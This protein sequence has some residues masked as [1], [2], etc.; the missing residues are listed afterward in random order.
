MAATQM[1]ALKFAL[2]VVSALAAAP[3]LRA[4][5]LDDSIAKLKAVQ[6]DGA[7]NTEA[8]NAY[9]K[10]VEAGPQQITKLLSAIE[11][12]GPLG[13]NWLRGAAEAIAIDAIEKKTLPAAD[14]ETFALDDSHDP[15]AR[16][17]AYEWVIAVDPAAADR[18]VPKLL[19]DPSVEFRRDAVQRLMEQGEKLF[20]S[21]K[22]ASGD[23]FLQAIGAARDE[24]QIKAIVEQLKK[25]ERPVDLQRHFGFLVDWQVIGPFDNT[26]R[27]GFEMAF[28]PEKERD[29]K[30]EYPGKSGQVKWQPL[31]SSDDYG[32]VD[33][34]QPY[35][36]LKET[37]A[38]AWTFFESPMDRDAELRL[39][40]KNAWKIWLNGELV[41]GR[42]EYHRGMSL[43]QYILPVKLKAGRNEILVKACQNEETQTWTTEWMFQLRVCDASGTAI[44]SA[45]RAATPRE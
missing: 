16:R 1:Q 19:N 14:L 13:A 10:I 45:D 27:A 11:G 7:G 33:F 4:G 23:I 2:A 28:P 5:D 21:D 40:C 43:D 32:M 12:A 35:T 31:H 34:N 20:A 37:T 6:A 26:G 30:A 29:L 18:I 3:S 8:A 25:L 22:A 36:P 9:G 42:D 38:Y 24:D 41:F 15:R 17:L 39:G 44:L